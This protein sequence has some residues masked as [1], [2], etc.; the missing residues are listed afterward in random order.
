MPEWVA[1]NATIADP[2][3][4]KEKSYFKSR[5]PIKPVPIHLV[6]R[7]TPNDM[8]SKAA[9][10]RVIETDQGSAKAFLRTRLCKCIARSAAFLPP[11]TLPRT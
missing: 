7:E 5:S 4:P 6:E 11:V 2:S 10:G 9:R 1:A 8:T 3:E